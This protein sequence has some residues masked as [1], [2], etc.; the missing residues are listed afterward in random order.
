VQ[1]FVDALESNTRDEP[2]LRV[3]IAHA[4]APERMVQ[5]EKMVRHIRPKAQIEMET[6]LGAVIGAHAGPGTVGFFW[7]SDD[8]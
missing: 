7:F 2:G 8:D 1:E 3:G 5:L 4:D 6:S